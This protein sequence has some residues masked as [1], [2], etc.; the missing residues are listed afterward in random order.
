MIVSSIYKVSKEQ[1]IKSSQALVGVRPV[2]VIKISAAVG[3]EQLDTL[4]SEKSS[5]KSSPENEKTGRANEDLS[6]L[7]VRAL[8]GTRS[9]QVPIVTTP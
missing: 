2:S 8:E 6:P 4:E 5:R 9:S 3:T 7:Q 1:Q